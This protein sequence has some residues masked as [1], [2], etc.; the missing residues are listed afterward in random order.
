MPAMGTTGCGQSIVD[1]VYSTIALNDSSM[2]S[3]TYYLRKGAYDADEIFG[4]HR[5]H[6]VRLA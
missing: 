1:R 4:F 2:E 5:H 6:A 3:P